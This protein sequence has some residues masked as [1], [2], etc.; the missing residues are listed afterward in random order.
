MD[1][2]KKLKNEIIE[3][4]KLLWDK[5]LASALNGNISVRV[6][7]KRIILTATKTCLG[8][9]IDKDLLVCDNDG[10]PLESGKV[11]S[12]KMLHTA[13]YKNFPDVKAIIHTHTPYVNGFFI[14]QPVFVPRIFE[15]KLYLGEVKAIEQYSPTVQDI[16]P[17]LAELKG[18]GLAVLRNHGVLAVGPELFDCFCWIQNL[19]EAIKTE[20]IAKVFKQGC[21]SEGAIAPEESKKRSFVNAQDD[22]T[23]AQDDKKKFFSREHMQAIVDIVNADE[24]MKQ[25]GSQTNMNMELAVK[26]D[27]TGEVFSFTFDKGKIVNLGNNANAEFMTSA[28]EVVWRAVFKR[29]LDPFV[30]TT[31]KKMVLKGDF[32][33]ISKWY[34]PCSRVFELWTR[35]AVE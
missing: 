3:I 35:V 31:Q 9:L 32:A 5:D 7:D 30:A 15:A 34:A 1:N 26:L 10:N 25:L 17:V 19:E 24:K 21:H 28:P 16:S 6:D 4:G 2:I 12:E 18:K 29:E 33:K 13:I 8:R 27:E 20:A 22:C 23:K 14:E 11:T